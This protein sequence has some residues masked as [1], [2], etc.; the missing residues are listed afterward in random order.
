M[1]IELNILS[2]A[3][4]SVLA[5]AVAISFAILIAYLVTGEQIGEFK[6]QLSLDLLVL[7]AGLTMQLLFRDD[8][9]AS[10]IVSNTLSFTFSSITFF[11]VNKRHGGIAFRKM[12]NETGVKAGFAGLGLMLLNALATVA[13]CFL[14][15][16]V[17]QII[18]LSID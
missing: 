12:P 8:C 18:V 13:L 15:S 11:E 17:F 14:L 3:F 16:I 4:L 1:A 7:I 10:A 6:E 5:A 9:T 2:I